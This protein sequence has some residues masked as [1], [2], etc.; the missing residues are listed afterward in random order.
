[1]GIVWGTL[2]TAITIAVLLYDLFV[3]LTLGEDATLSRYVRRANEFWPLMGTS[4]GFFIGAL[5]GHFFW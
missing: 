2:A 4:L 1:M 3:G 5:F